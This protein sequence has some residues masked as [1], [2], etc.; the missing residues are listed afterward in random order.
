VN[1]NMEIEQLQ[2]I[3]ADHPNDAVKSCNEM[4]EKWLKKEVDASWEQLFNAIDHVT[5]PELFSSVPLQGK[6]CTVKGANPP[7]TKR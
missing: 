5:L 7:K 3:K 2:I 1:L 4:W 6:K